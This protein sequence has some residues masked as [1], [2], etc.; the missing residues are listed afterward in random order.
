MNISLDFVFLSYLLQF[1]KSQ[2]NRQD[3]ILGYRWEDKRLR[4]LYTPYSKMAAT[5]DGLGRVARKRGIEGHGRQHSQWRPFETTL[6][7]V[8]R[9]WRRMSFL[10]VNSTEEMRIDW[11]ILSWSFG[12][13]VVAIRA[14]DCPQK[15]NFVLSPQNN[16][17]RCCGLDSQSL[18]SLSG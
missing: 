2:V 9:F 6:C 4:H 12:L 14:K 10:A 15:R 7:L 16:N 13:S 3:L 18:H 8:H 17:P 1:V 11:R 5:Q